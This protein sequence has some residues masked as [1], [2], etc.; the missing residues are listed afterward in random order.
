MTMR[1]KRNWPPAE[2]SGQPNRP[3]HGGAAV[4]IADD[5]K[6]LPPGSMPKALLVALLTACLEVSPALVAWLERGVLAVWPE[7][8]GV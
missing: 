6:D 3:M 2:T 5:T 7:M 4:C 1:T 8:R